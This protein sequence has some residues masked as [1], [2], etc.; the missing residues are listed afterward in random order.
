M[1]LVVADNWRCKHSNCARSTVE[2]IK[3]YRP[4]AQGKKSQ[5]QQE[6]R[7]LEAALRNFDGA[8]KTYRNTLITVSCIIVELMVH[9]S[10]NP[11]SDAHRASG[12]DS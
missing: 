8:D 5:C 4:H 11:I 10:S 12:E 6:L 1:G 7:S 9:R 3:A 2:L